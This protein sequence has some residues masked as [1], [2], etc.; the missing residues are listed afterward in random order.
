MILNKEFIVRAVRK[1]LEYSRE[2]KDFYN[3]LILK[4]LDNESDSTNMLENIIKGI[5]LE[6]N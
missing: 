4:S 6:T 5:F 1:E 2:Y 3:D